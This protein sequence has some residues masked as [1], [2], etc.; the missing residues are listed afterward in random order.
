M[1]KDWRKKFKCPLCFKDVLYLVKCKVC[2]KK[3]CEYCTV[4]KKCKGC[5]DEKDNT[6]YNDFTDNNDYDNVVS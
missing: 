4:D 6:K 1:S 5:F 2:C 3:N